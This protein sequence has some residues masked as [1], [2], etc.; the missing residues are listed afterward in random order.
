MEIELFNTLYK[1][2]NQNLKYKTQISELLSK[3]ETFKMHLTD[4]NQ[5][6]TLVQN[7]EFE[8]AA[9]II[10]YE[11]TK[12]QMAQNLSQEINQQ[13][14]NIAQPLAPLQQKQPTIITQPLAPLQQKQPTDITQPLSPLQ[15]KQHTDITQPFSSIQLHIDDENYDR[16]PIYEYLKN[17]YMTCHKVYKELD[18]D[19][20]NIE[21]WLD[22]NQQN[23]RYKEVKKCY[24]NL[25][26]VPIDDYRKI[27]K[28]L[29]DLK[30]KCE[31]LVGNDVIECKNY[32]RERNIDI[33][34]MDDY[35]NKKIGT[36]EYAK[37]DKC[38]N[39]KRELYAEKKCS[40]FYVRF[41]VQNP[42]N[43]DSF[44]VQIDDIY[45]KNRIDQCKKIEFPF[46]QKKVK[47]K[48]IDPE[49]FKLED[50]KEFITNKATDIMNKFY[51]Y[52]REGS[53]GKKI[54]VIDSNL[55]DGNIISQIL[56]NDIGYQ[57]EIYDQLI[58][59]N[60]DLI[61]CEENNYGLRLLF[62]NIGGTAFAYPVFGFYD[63]GIKKGIYVVKIFIKPQDLKLKTYQSAFK[64]LT[65]F[66]QFKNDYDN[67]LHVVKGYK[68]DQECQ[69]DKPLK[70]TPLN[71]RYKKNKNDDNYEYEK[72]DLNNFLKSQCDYIY[73]YKTNQQIANEY[74]NKVQTLIKFI[75][76]DK[77]LGS[78]DNIIKDQQKRKRYLDIG[79]IH[80][81]GIYQSSIIKFFI[82]TKK[83]NIIE[84]K[85]I[86]IFTRADPKI[87]GKRLISIDRIPLIISN[88]TQFDQFCE[89]I[90]N[91]IETIVSGLVIKKD[92]QIRG[93]T[94]L[95]KEIKIIGRLENSANIF[96]NTIVYN[97]KNNDTLT[98]E[99][100]YFNEN[101]LLGNN[102]N[103]LY[104]D[105]TYYDLTEQL[106]VLYSRNKD[107]PQET[108]MKKDYNNL[109]QGID[110]LDK[111][112][113]DFYKKRNDYSFMVATRSNEMVSIISPTD[114]KY[115]HYKS[116]FDTYS[117]RISIKEEKRMRFC[118]EYKLQNNN[119][120]AQFL[121][122]EFLTG[123]SYCDFLNNNKYDDSLL[124]S[125][126]I[127]ILFQIEYLF[128]KYK[129]VHGDLH[130]NNIMYT[131]D[132]NYDAQ[133]KQF[134]EYKYFDY[135][136]NGAEK[137]IYIPVYE[138]ILKIIDFDKSLFYLNYITEANEIINELK[139]IQIN[140]NYVLSPNSI[141]AATYIVDDILT[142][143]TDIFDL[144]NRFNL[145]ENGQG[146][147]ISEDFNY[148]KRFGKYEENMK[149]LY[150]KVTIDTKN[151]INPKLLSIDSNNGLVPIKLICKL[152]II[153]LYQE[154]IRLV[155]HFKKLN[156]LF[157]NAIFVDGDILEKFDEVFNE[158][159]DLFENYDIN[160]D[161][162]MVDRVTAQNNSEPIKKDI[163]FHDYISIFWTSLQISNIFSSIINDQFKK[164]VENIFT[165]SVSAENY[166][167]Y[168]K[169]RLI[170]APGD[171]IFFI[172]SLLISLKHGKNKD[173]S[174]VV[175]DD[176]GQQH[177]NPK[178]LGAIK[179]IASVL[180]DE[181]YCNDI[182]IDRPLLYQFVSCLGHCINLIGNTKDTSVYEKL[183]IDSDKLQYMWYDKGIK[184]IF[185]GTSQEVNGL[186]NLHYGDSYSLLYLM[187]PFLET[188]FDDIPDR[189]NIVQT[190]D[191]TKF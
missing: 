45:A 64:E 17:E 86:N 85:I 1:L 183:T 18:I 73:N 150:S 110:L 185:L 74:N 6:T 57:K 129:M 102:K 13:F 131:H 113:S 175:I 105:I 27:I 168:Y 145:D 182:S 170:V 155:D 101:G 94:S 26:F 108:K 49:L 15:Q 130:V 95:I 30:E 23:E 55:Y 52:I 148:T 191:L 22:K 142:A 111:E 133:K 70:L 71:I 56:Q 35:F 152:V 68:L 166:T 134:Y 38:L 58:K 62:A 10:N 5:I 80:E 8:K 82:G 118:N 41:G 40:D 164:V 128:Y 138:Y 19:L 79:F 99:I 176:N 78:I 59:E 144:D 54:L 7:S 162:E 172:A 161:L 116:L 127:Q 83:V 24:E 29:E 141:K 165:Y 103:N 154:I 47:I 63:D 135:G 124:I 167:P 114:L 39:Y 122:E 107:I 4:Y 156:E 87:V 88:Q 177:Y 112:K 16:K 96:E 43:I 12:Q 28:Q 151:K 37:Y 120:T 171:T 174:L 123:G 42:N 14:T 137:S 188:F 136:N 147:M 180:S 89:H 91:H 126:V 132:Y 72:I 160:N 31:E 104:F 46:G 158:G 93:L 173:G 157:K 125:G 117:R 179:N 33:F 50:N 61:K 92:N 186:V 36:N 25:Q 153:V 184:E 90:G 146:I 100:L 121:F 98:I 75:M 178:E 67:L 189:A 149:S 77:K 51:T 60:K 9:R 143:L 109:I 187:R 163:S 21:L 159:L 84:R 65:F 119:Y 66:E 181:Q 97:N 20:K 11:I 3:I 140:N 115:I 139:K 32:L 76:Y 169:D 106:R 53:V 44:N 34:D 48:D 69:S 2:L 81:P 190:I